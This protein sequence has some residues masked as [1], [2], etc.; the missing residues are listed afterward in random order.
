M[1]QRTTTNSSSVP[2]APATTTTTTPSM[3]AAQQQWWTACC[4]MGLRLTYYA[5]DEREEVFT[6]LRF[7][8]ELHG[9]F[10]MLHGG[11]SAVLVDEVA[12]WTMFDRYRCFGFTLDMQLKYCK[13]IKL[14]ELEQEEEK[15]EEKQKECSPKPSCPKQGPNEPF[16]ERLLDHLH[17][18]YIKV[19]GKLNQQKTKP[20]DRKIYLDVRL[21]DRNGDTCVLAEV[22]FLIANKD[23]A[24]RVL[25]PQLAASLQEFLCDDA[26]VARTLT[27]ARL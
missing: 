25:G 2:A 19:V 1:L 7:R 14:F 21:V 22:L 20:G 16:S 12:F 4:P 3:A 11:L 27:P 5:D 23:T 8:K 26:P 18:N 24:E 15:A 10:S 9:F 17:Y 13:P 6:V